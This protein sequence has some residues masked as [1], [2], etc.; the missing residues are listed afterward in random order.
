MSNY[1]I[2]FVC[3]FLFVFAV[4]V[5]LLGSWQSQVVVAQTLSFETEIFSDE[6]LVK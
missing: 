5:W 4:H 1:K 3:V 2:F 6:E